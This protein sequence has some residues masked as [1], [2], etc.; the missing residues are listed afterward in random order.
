MAS[1]DRQFHD[2]LRAHLGRTGTSGRRFGVEALGD[3]GFAASLAR[4]RRL[5]LKT[6]DRVLAFIGTAPLAPAFRREVEAFLTNTGTKAY[7]LGEQ[8]AGDPSFVERLRR[9]ASFRLA[10]ESGRTSAP[11]MEQG[12]GAEGRRSRSRAVIALLRKLWRGGSGSVAELCLCREDPRRESHP[13]IMVESKAGIERVARVLGA[14]E[15]W[16]RSCRCRR[17]SPDRRRLGRRCEYGTSCPR[18]AR[19]M[20]RRRSVRRHPSRRVLP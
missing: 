14:V 11:A 18:T 6:A 17:S 7:V 5:G 8:A 19:E 3:P 4:G 12:P 1:L 9:G 20:A 2:L 16:V 10:T 15:G 13:T